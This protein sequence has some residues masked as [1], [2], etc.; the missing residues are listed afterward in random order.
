LNIK[1]DS[2]GKLD[3]TYVGANAMY[4]NRTVSGTR[5]QFTSKQPMVSDLM[6]C[7]K[8]KAGETGLFYMVHCDSELEKLFL[9]NLCAEND[10]YPDNGKWYHTWSDGH[11]LDFTN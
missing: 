9:S 8:P 3:P 10:G 5:R 7:L 6:P 4:V 11:L 2:V 1:E